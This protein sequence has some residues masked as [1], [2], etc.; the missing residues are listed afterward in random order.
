MKKLLIKL[1]PSAQQGIHVYD[2]IVIIAVCGDK[3]VGDP[4][5]V[6]AI[7]QRLLFGLLDPLIDI[8]FDLF[9]F[10]LFGLKLGI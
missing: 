7:F 8:V 3:I 1:N 4:Y 6:W 5:T 9:V 2:Y 10:C